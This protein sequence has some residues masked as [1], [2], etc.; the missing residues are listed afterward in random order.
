MSFQPHHFKTALL[1]PAK[2][3]NGLRLRVQPLRIHDFIPKNAHFPL[4]FI[5]IFRISEFPESRYPENSPI[6]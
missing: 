6:L 2:G 5:Q 4:V 1:V 3:R